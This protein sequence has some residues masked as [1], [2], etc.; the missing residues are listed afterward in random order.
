M[1]QQRMYGSL[2]S[3]KFRKNLK[4]IKT[5]NLSSLKTKEE[6]SNNVEVQTFSVLFDKIFQNICLSYFLLE[7]GIKKSSCYGLI[8]LMNLMHIFL[9]MIQFDHCTLV[10]Y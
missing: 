3:Q 4:A 1:S 2:P 5:R 9:L 7:S 10:L 8:Y 6:L